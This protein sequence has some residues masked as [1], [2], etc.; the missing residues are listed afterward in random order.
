MCKEVIKGDK[1]KLRLIGPSIL[2]DWDTKLDLCEQCKQK[3][4]R[5]IKGELES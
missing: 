2:S 5:F 3:V 4:G 1:Y